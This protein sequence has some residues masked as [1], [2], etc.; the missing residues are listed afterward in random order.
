MAAKE[1][2]EVIDDWL[3]YCQV[4]LL[5]VPKTKFYSQIQ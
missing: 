2:I 5:A 1:E 3:D 4:H